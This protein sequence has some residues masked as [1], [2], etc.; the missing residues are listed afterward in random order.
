M[1]KSRARSRSADGASRT[2]QRI[3]RATVALM[4]EIG[5]DRVRTRTI[6]ERAGVNPAL[7][8]Y[9]FGSVSALVLEAAE[10]ALRRELGPSIDVLRSGTTMKASLHAVLTWIERYGERSA[11]A[12]IL[13]EAM[14]KATRD[15]SFRRWTKR[16]SER[17]RSAILER[18]EAAR[19]AG[20]LDANLDLT[21]AARAAR[22]LAGRVAVPPSRRSD[23]GRHA[24]GRAAR[25]DA[26]VER[27]SARAPDGETEREVSSGGR[28]REERRNEKDEAGPVRR[29]A[30]AGAGAAAGRGGRSGRRRAAARRGGHREAR[31]RLLAR[32]HVVHRDRHDGAP[33]RLRAPVGD[34]RVDARAR[35]TRWCASRSPPATPAMPR[36][37]LGDDMWVFTPR[38]NRVVKIP[39]SM[40]ASSWMGSDFSYNDLAKSDELVVHFDSRIVGD[41]DRAT[42]TRCTSSRPRPIR[43]RR[44]SGARRWSRSATTTCCSR[45]PSSTR[46]ASRSS[47]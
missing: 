37:K 14:V 26:R 44:S 28:G 43:R 21:A 45:R 9:H 40:M 39:F 16:A 22:R 7:I 15:P 11:G 46:T 31:H 32:Q 4:A 23:A 41:R 24:G 6:A 30:R 19:D 18:L 35:R 36:S 47:G 2:R 33:A 20:E 5:I 3:L 1:T 38:L 12:T 10:D 17:F 13:A 8:H 34:A 29:G 42:A 27:P 25:G